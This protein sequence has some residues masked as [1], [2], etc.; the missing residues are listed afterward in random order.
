MFFP[1]VTAV[2]FLLDC[3]GAQAF[4][5]WEVKDNVG[6]M[7]LELE[8]VEPAVRVN[9]MLHRAAY[10]AGMGYSLY[11]PEHMVNYLPQ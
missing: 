8:Q 6:R 5:P 1:P 7:K 10:R 11:S 4:K 3:A 9:E 2:D